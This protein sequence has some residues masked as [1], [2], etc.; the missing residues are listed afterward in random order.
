MPKQANLLIFGSNEGKYF[1]DN[2][3]SLFE[4][5]QANEESIKAVWFTNNKEV[6]RE[7][8]ENTLAM[9]SCPPVSRPRFSI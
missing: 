8:E 1:S 2:S 5:I 3:R 7:V 9:S 4:Y 6:Y